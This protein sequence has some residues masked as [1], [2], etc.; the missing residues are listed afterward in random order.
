MN[1]RSDISKLHSQYPDLASAYER[2]CDEVNTPLRDL[3]DSENW[4]TVSRRR[5]TAADELDMC[6][7]KIRMLPG[8][9]RFLLGQTATEMQACA[10][11]GSIVVINATDMRSDAIIVSS[12]EIKTLRLSGLEPSKVKEWLQKKWTG[13]RSDRGKRNREYLKYLSWLWKACVKKVLDEIGNAPRPTAED[14]PRIWWIGTGL[15]SSMPFHAAGEHSLDSTENAY[16]RAI[17]SYVPSIRALSH[18]RD[19]LKNAEAMQR[20]LLI[21][22]MITSPCLKDL[23]GAIEEKYSVVQATKGFMTIEELDQPNASQIVESLKRCT[24][25]HFACHGY[26]DHRDPSNSGLVFQVCVESKPQQDVLTVRNIS[27]INSKQAR[28]PYLSACS[29][30]ENRVAQ[31]ADEVIHIVSGF[32]VAGFAHVIGCLWPSLD[33]VCVE[34]ARGFYSSLFRQGGVQWSNR[35]VAAALQEAVMSIRERD[36]G[37]PLNWAQFVHY[38]I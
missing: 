2:L 32:Q 10:R 8:Y 6:I 22:T 1:D 17:S 24:I 3:D 25:A 38:G 35:E 33:T 37:Q 36:L 31:L 27:E 21:A 7:Q 28:I 30:A 18:S 20:Q 14:L 12:T 34:V 4:M 29:T 5:R 19:C 9:D 13:R 11:E 16:H 15:A 26:T 23:P